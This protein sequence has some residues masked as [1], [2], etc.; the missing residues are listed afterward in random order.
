[1][2]K[3][4]DEEPITVQRVIEFIYCGYYTEPY[5][6]AT[7]N[8]GSSKAS[9]NKYC[10]QCGPDAP[11]LACRNHRRRASSA[12]FSA[13]S[14]DIPN[15]TPGF[16]TSGMVAA[17]Q[18]S[19]QGQI[20]SQAD[21]ED[22]SPG[23]AEGKIKGGAPPESSDTCELKMPNSVCNALVYAAA[24]KF[25]MADLMD[26]AAAKFTQSFPQDFA[27]DL[28]G[29]VEIVF[30]GDWE[31]LQE[32]VAEVCLK[33]YD[34]L[35]DSE[36][37]EKILRGGGP[38]GFKMLHKVKKESE[39]KAKTDDRM[40]GVAR[41]MAGRLNSELEREKARREAAERKVIWGTKQYWNSLH[42]LNKNTKCRKCK[43]DF[44]VTFEL[45]SERGDIPSRA[46]LRCRSCAA[47]H[48][49]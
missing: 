43:G 37:L 6:T 7:E 16:D 20:D 10:D 45:G 32:T 38:L 13:Y 18:H 42:M 5:P 19:I 33:H 11:C 22:N 9:Y 29:V 28:P 14:D 12:S 41:V 44:G 39:L 8:G 48:N 21:A 40:L 24:D 15:W 1:V 26:V 47:T 23:L 30:T 4:D 17:L 35:M 36:D 34:M 31:R 2:L 3:L 49:R 27:K 25:Q 46:V